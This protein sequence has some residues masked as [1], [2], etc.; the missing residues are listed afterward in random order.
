MSQLSEKEL[1]ALNDLLTEEELLVKKFKMLSEHSEDQEI[2]SKFT[3]ISNKHQG[4]Y[5]SLYSKLG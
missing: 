5:N 2:K 3:E 1:S 4:H